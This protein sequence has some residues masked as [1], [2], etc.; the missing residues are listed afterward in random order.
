MHGGVKVG[1]G[2]CYNGSRRAARED[3]CSMEGTP[4][5]EVGPNHGRPPSEK[6]HIIKAKAICD[7]PLCPRS[8]GRGCSR[9]KGECGGQ[10]AAARPSRGGGC[11]GGECDGEGVMVPMR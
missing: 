1:S 2:T 11:K 6:G 9:C 7:S 5:S 8:K 3:G 4:M 10:G